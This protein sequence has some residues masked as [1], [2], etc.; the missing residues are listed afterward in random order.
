MQFMKRDNDPDHGDCLAAI[1]F[2]CA[3]IMHYEE[4]IRRGVLPGSL[5]DMP[6]YDIPVPAPAWQI[7]GCE[8]VATFEKLVR[9]LIP[10]ILAD[11]TCCVA[12][13]TS[14]KSVEQERIY[15]SGPISTDDPDAYLRNHQLGQLIGRTLEDKGHIVFTPHNYVVRGPDGVRVSPSKYEA[16]LA[17]DL[18]IV[19]LWA[20]ALFRI[21]ASPGADRELEIATDRKLKIYHTLES[22]PVV[23]RK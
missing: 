14:N 4:L 16:L 17:L 20:T 8:P 13:K 21:D 9:S 19:K 15:V 10:E 23:N 22:V 11:E 12:R 2:W 1:R 5:D 3:A 18:S 6:K 7:Q